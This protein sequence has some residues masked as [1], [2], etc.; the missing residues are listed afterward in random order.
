[1]NKTIISKKIFTIII[2]VL[3]CLI[4][5]LNVIKADDTKIVKVGW[6]SSDMFQEGMSD[7]EKKS[8][9]AYDYLQKI[10]DYTNWKYEYVYGA[11]FLKNW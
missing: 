5:S 7:D 8:G 11:I 1:M 10:S 9:Y 4:S 6:Y 3:L 2:T